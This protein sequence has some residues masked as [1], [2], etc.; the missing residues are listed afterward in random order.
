MRLC[1]GLNVYRQASSSDGDYGV[2]DILYQIRVLLISQLDEPT[3]YCHSIRH[4]EMRL[5]THVARR[6]LWDQCRG[7]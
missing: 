4:K 5:H 3:G 7:L 1:L 6:L 2:S